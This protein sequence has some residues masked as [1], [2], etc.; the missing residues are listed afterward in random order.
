[1]VR[2]AAVL[3]THAGLRTDELNRLEVGCIRELAPGLDPELR[4]EL[5]RDV[6][7]LV[8]LLSIPT[9][10][11]STAFTK[12]VGK[13]VG[14]YVRAWEAERGEQPTVLDRKTRQPTHYLF[15]R[16]GRKLG[17]RFLSGRGRRRGA[18]D[19]LIAKRRNVPTPDGRTPA[20][21]NSPPAAPSFIP[22]SQLTG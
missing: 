15:M 22:L 6:A 20:Q 13:I 4:E 14:Q 2:A 11:T 8:C 3:W 12:P 16:R 1:L 9:N 17:G 18:M 10:K 7:D 19:H 21:I 5:G